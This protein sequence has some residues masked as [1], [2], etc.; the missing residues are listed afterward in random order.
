MT[1]SGKGGKDYGA[2]GGAGG[3]DTDPNEY[4]DGG[5]GA[6]GLVYIEWDPLPAN[7]TWA[8]F[9]ETGTSSFVPPEGVTKFRVLMV[10]GGAGGTMGYSGAGGS[11]LVKGQEVD[12][13]GAS[14][15]QITV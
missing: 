8:L 3:Y 5:E 6:D 9:N 1:N 2:S 10:G 14:S 7:K 4:G 12:I 15:V 11:G 13:G